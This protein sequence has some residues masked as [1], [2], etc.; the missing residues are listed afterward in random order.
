MAH[1]PGTADAP[2]RGR[3]RVPRSWY[4]LCLA[5]ARVAHSKDADTCCA[6]LRLTL[7]G[8]ELHRAFMHVA[9]VCLRPDPLVRLCYAVERRTMSTE[10]HQLQEKRRSLRQL[11]R[12]SAAKLFRVKHEAQDF[13][14]AY[15][16]SREAEAA[17]P[18]TIPCPVCRLLLD[19]GTSP[20]RPV[21]G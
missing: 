11:Q 16:K 14:H 10:L 6:A 4:V 9:V 17:K 18:R 3:R 20:T 8:Q 12:V 5:A 7:P 13:E 21:W 15:A 1:Y 2:R 19:L